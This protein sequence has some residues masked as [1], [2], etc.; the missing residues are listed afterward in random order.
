MHMPQSRL[1][2]VLLF[3]T[4]VTIA[5]ELPGKR[6][7]H[8]M[9]YDESNQ[10]VIMSGGSTAVNGGSSF[11]FYDDVWSFDGKNWNKEKITGDQRSGIS[12]AYDSRRKKILSLGGFMNNVTKSDLRI[13]SNNT[14]TLLSTLPEPG[15]TEGGFVYDQQ[16]DKFIA[17]GGGASRGIINAN[18]WLWDGKKWKK[19]DIKGPD[20]RQAFAMVYDSKRNKTVL[21]GGMGATPQNLYGDTWEYDGT[22]WKKVSDNGPAARMAMGYT[23]D[24]K[25]G[26]MI[27]FSGSSSAGILSDMWAWDGKEWKQLPFS[28]GPAPRMMGY[29]S[30]DS[31]RDMVVL[32]GGRLGWPNDAN[33]TWEWNGELWTEIK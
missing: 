16:Q 3:I 21:F 15:M 18:T 25:R 29:L 20:G 12:L 31:K 32:F 24:T 5:Q 4:S 17:F 8:A 22:E 7:H 1:Y 10:K 2:I 13:A 14:W 27:I 28:S 19:Q 30:Y 26:T 33:D 23:Y 6:A 11:K 9:I